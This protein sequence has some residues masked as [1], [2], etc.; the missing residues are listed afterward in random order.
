MTN[1]ERIAARLSG[2]DFAGEILDDAWAEVVTARAVEYLTSQE[3]TELQVE[4][5]DPMEA[6]NE[7]VSVVLREFTIYLCRQYGV[8]P[9]DL[10]PPCLDCKL[11]W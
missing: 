11:P 6:V 2:H 1:I 7:G 8:G 10:E 4:T 3:I 9:E 5:D